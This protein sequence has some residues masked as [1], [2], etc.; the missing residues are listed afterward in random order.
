MQTLERTPTQSD[1]T[2]IATQ[3]CEQLA[4]GQAMMKR[5]LGLKAE[6]SEWKCP[7]M[8]KPGEPVYCGLK[9]CDRGYDC[10]AE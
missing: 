5:V 7:T 1:E 8:S 6:S 2:L 3:P 4:T 9:E 10:R